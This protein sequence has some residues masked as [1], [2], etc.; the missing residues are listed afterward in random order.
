MDLEPQTQNFI[1]QM[2]E[3]K[4]LIQAEGKTRSHTQDVQALFIM[5]NAK[6]H[7]FISQLSNF[8]DMITLGLAIFFL[9]F[10]FKKNHWLIGTVIQQSRI[11]VE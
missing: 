1:N 6:N 3:S 2:S 9:F 4:I 7:T 10:F 8:V 11:I 5:Y